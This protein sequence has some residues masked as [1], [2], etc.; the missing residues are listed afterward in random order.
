MG[1]NP[2]QIA[3]IGRRLYERRRAEFEVHNPGKYVLIDIRTEKIY[4]AE[5]PEAA[6]QQATAEPGDGPYYIVRVGERAAFRSRR[7]RHGD[8][9]RVAR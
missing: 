3:R 5:T 2:R 1:F 6:Y 9:A 7:L 8:A 4:V